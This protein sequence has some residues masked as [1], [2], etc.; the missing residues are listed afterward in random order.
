MARTGSLKKRNPNGAGRKTLYS[1]ERVNKLIDA[2]KIGATVDQA[3]AYAGIS[4]QT[5]Y[6]WADRHPEFLTEMQSAQY[7]P[8]LVAKNIVVDAIVKDKDLATAKWW[9][10]KKEFKNNAQIQVNNVDPASDNVQIIGFNYIAP[11]DTQPNE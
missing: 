10:E 1:K 11:K 7:Y 5:Y 2:F 8:E 3:V 4:K 6:D 9:L